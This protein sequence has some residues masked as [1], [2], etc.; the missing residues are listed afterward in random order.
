MSRLRTILATG[1]SATS[2]SS[3]WPG[4]CRQALDG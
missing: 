2:A 3:L 1:Q 4:L